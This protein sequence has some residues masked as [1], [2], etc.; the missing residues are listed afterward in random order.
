M[1]DDR[2]TFTNPSISVEENAGTVRLT[3]WT[4]ISAGESHRIE[5]DA[6]EALSFLR[7]L[8][9]QVTYAARY[10]LRAGVAGDCSTCQNVRLVVVQNAAGRDE[11]VHCPDCSADGVPDAAYPRIGGG[12]R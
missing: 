11:R 10:A 3:V 2:T 4:D 8:A 6:V 5:L 9:I 12:V 1:T 7:D